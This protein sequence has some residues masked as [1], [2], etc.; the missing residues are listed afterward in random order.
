LLLIGRQLFL[1]AP[2]LLVPSAGGA[3][4]PVPVPEL[5]TRVTDLTGTLEA[6]QADALE[7]KLTALEDE[8]GTQIAVLVVPTVR[9]EAI[10]QFAL[11]VVESW[12]L[13]R[14]DVDDGALMLVA[15]EDR[16]VRIEVGYGLEGALTDATSRRII[17]EAVLPHFR[18]G[19]MY[20]GLAA[21]VDRMIA[22]ARGEGLPPP[23]ERSPGEGPSTLLPFAFAALFVAMIAGGIL[24]ALLGRVLG[25]TA[26]G[27][28]TG[29]IVFAMSSVLGVAALAGFGAF[30]LTLVVGGTRGWSS[31]GRSGGFGRGGGWFGGGGGGFGGGGFGG[32]GFG[33]G[34]FSGGGGSFGGGGASGSW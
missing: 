2:L 24:R 26:T 19:D 25:A 5:R 22:V 27:A 1:T 14:E 34:G 3:Q 31:R 13:G 10:E 29:G 21:G 12:R 7:A 6:S 28:L 20:G 4:D 33:G 9:P 8:T 32:G 16:E 30:F 11:R 23:Q 18:T 15:L 17:D